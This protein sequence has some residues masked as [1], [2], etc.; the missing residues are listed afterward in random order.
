ML[1]F[2]RLISPLR[3][4]FGCWSG[5]GAVSSPRMSSCSCCG[6]SWSCS[7][8][9]N[10]ARGC[11]PPILPCLQRRRYCAGIESSCAASGRSRGG[12]VMSAEQV[13]EIAR[14]IE[15]QEVWVPADEERR[16]Y[17]D[18][19]D[20]VVFYCAEFGAGRRLARRTRRAHFLG[21]TCPDTRTSVRSVE[22]SIQQASGNPEPRRTNRRGWSSSDRL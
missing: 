21:E 8:A 22:M 15:C 13:A 4:H 6:T 16:A 7:D 17:L 1:P 10:D 12:R 5:A 11:G 9:K 20:K 3:L 19:D 18:T 14:C 2:L